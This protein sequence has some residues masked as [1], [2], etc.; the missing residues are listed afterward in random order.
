MCAKR[1]GY[2]MYDELDP[3]EFTHFGCGLLTL[4]FMVSIPLSVILG[5]VVLIALRFVS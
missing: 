3:D 2:L 1:V 4:L 5:G